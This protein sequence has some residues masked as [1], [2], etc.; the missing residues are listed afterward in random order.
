MGSAALSPWRHHRPGLNDHFLWI[1]ESRTRCFREWQLLAHL[2]DLGLPAPKPVA[3]HYR[4]RGWSYT[5]DLVTVRI[6][7]V[8]PFS[9]RLQRGK[10][11][12]TIWAD[13]G[14]CIAAFHGAHIYHADL[15]AHNLQIDS[16]NRIFLLDF[17]RGR[18]RHDRR[19]WRAA[20]LARLHRSL[21]KISGTRPE[22]ESRASFG[23]REWEW[24]MAGYQTAASHRRTIP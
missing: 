11:D 5:A 4:R 13:V 18:V 12:A 15:T 19:D 21:I 22:G 6:P 14:R 24:L 2:Q 9:S 17:D 7:D 10:T 8:E 1:S 20:N 3:A 23:V 16:A